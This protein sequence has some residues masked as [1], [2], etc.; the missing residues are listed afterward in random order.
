MN[1]ELL[2]GTFHRPLVLML[3]TLL[4]TAGAIAV[5]AVHDSV[6]AQE[7]SRCA[8]V[9]LGQLSD[10]AGPGLQAEGSWGTEGCDSRFR[11]GSDAVNFEFAVQDAGRI[12][13]ELTS[14][15]ADSYLYLLD[16]SG[17]RI[18]DNDD[19]GLLLNARVERELAPGAYRVEATTVG[20]RS[21]GAADFSLTVG[22]VE[23]C[24][25][26]PL[27]ALVP[28][29][30]LTASGSLSHQTC[31]SRIVVAHPA[32][33]YL[34][35]LPEPG[36]VRID[37]SSPNGDPVLSMATLAGAVIGANDDG[38][39]GRSARIEQ[40]L[41]SGTYIIEATT[42]R[43][44][45]L[46]PLAADFNLTVR[47][48]DELQRQQLADPK[49]EAL[50]VPEQVTAGEPFTVHYRVGNLGGGD[51]HE[52]AP[53]VQIQ[54]YGPGAGGGFS[55]QW[56]YNLAV[57]ESN[58]GAGA[59]Y[60]SS[61]AVASASSTTLDRVESQ[62]MTLRGHGQSWVLIALFV[63]DADHRDIGFH[64]VWKHIDVIEGATF[65]P[66]R[67]RVDDLLYEVAATAD[68]EGRVTRT[69]SNL[70]DREAEVGLPQRSQAIYAA[71]VRGLLLD[72]IFARPG[73]ARL[74]ELRAG[75]SSSLRSSNIPTGPTSGAVRDAFAA[76][77]MAALADS[78]LAE[79]DSA[80]LMI[81]P[82]RVEDL[83]LAGARTA[84][85]RYASLAANWR[86][87]QANSGA[88]AYADALALHSQLRY[89]EA[90]LA[91]LIEAGELVRAARAD[92][93]GW[94]GAV[95]EQLVEFAREAICSQSARELGRLLASAGG[96]DSTAA[97]ELDSELRLALPVFG[98]VTDAVLCAIA[99]VDAANDRLFNLL[100]MSSFQSVLLPGYRYNPAA[101]DDASDPQRLR[102]L[103]RRHADGSIEH[104][105]QLADG[106]IIQ[107]QRRIL[108]ANA[109]IGR[110]YSSG[111]VEIFGQSVG[112][113]RSQRNLEGQI[114]LGF[115]GSDGVLIEPRARTM[116]ADASTGVWLRTSQIEVP[117]A[118]PVLATVG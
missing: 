109:P 118:A 74:E 52:T 4:I 104:A 108:A 65:A 34:F 78:G 75:A 16:A 23:A 60:H 79:S 2:R 19:G 46:Q 8:V 9:D 92:D 1:V 15:S 12:R 42:Y 80:G 41:P 111:A 57:T 85:Q 72:G 17:N 91:P 3:L 81:D 102:I 43:R 106:R 94:D 96:A 14:D 115:L 10:P 61:D 62:E 112:V 84:A 101:P 44:G 13:I 7:E 48:I 99:E 20:G 70:A 90:A 117:P 59:S 50:V 32:Q 93:D 29:V 103:A 11:P 113:I 83:V 67:V 47:I 87:L 27:G 89:A 28:G 56:S 77:Y 76:D 71:G 105:V 69:V 86:T 21:R 98:N 24:E 114:L 37:L 116:P 55:R 63:L 82:G 88:T 33:N 68:A 66:T 18:A 107:P 58:W 110:W 30:D 26:I 51:L 49:V 53:L 100:G 38:G 54:G 95:S 36:R 5:I 40:F 45:G 39:Q 35:Q 22:Y 6:S 64:S 73:A 97:L 25:I 31:G